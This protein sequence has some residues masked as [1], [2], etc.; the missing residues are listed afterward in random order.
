MMIM[1][2]TNMTII[3]RKLMDRPQNFSFEIWMN[4][5][6]SPLTGRPPVRM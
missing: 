4:S 5:W 3:T 2:M 6:G 1:T